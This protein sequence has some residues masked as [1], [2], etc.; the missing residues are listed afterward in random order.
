MRQLKREPL[1]AALKHHKGAYE[2]GGKS[3]LD[4]C[5]GSCPALAWTQ[6]HTDVANQRAVAEASK[7]AC[8]EILQDDIKHTVTILVGEKCSM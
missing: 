6:T 4:F 1:C 2:E 3:L 7:A 5:T 8:K